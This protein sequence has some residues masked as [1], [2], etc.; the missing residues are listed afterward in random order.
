MQ[1]V[2]TWTGALALVAPSVLG[3][4]GAEGDAGPQGDSSA[5]LGGDNISIEVEGGADDGEGAR[6]DF[7]G[8]IEGIDDVAD[9]ANITVNDSISLTVKYGEEASVGSDGVEFEDSNESIVIA[10]VE[11]HENGFDLVTEASGQD[12]LSSYPVDLDVPESASMSVENDAV[13]IEDEEGVYAVFQHPVAVDGN[14]ETVDAWYEWEGST[15]VQRIDASAIGG[16]GVTLQSGWSYTVNHWYGKTPLEAENLVRNTCFNCYFP[17]DG[18]PAA[19]PSVGQ[20]LP[21]TVSVLGQTINF[22]V[23]T[24]AFT[25]TT[26]RPDQNFYFQ[27]TSTANHYYG[28]GYEINFSFRH[29]QDLVVYADVPLTGLLTRGQANEMWRQ[30]AENVRF[31]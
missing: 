18:A 11:P 20:V 10:T 29:N 17:V 9:D 25:S 16:G 22:E 15:L 8:S 7:Q 3:N 28:A 4:G 30:F 19:F 24:T 13:Y 31:G 23:A 6:I 27:L 5:S 14:G 26:L 1:K 12:I 21:L 2:L